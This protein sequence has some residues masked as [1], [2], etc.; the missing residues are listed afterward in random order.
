MVRHIICDFV[1]NP[2]EGRKKNSKFAIGNV[3]RVNL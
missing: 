3:M 2:F 1:A